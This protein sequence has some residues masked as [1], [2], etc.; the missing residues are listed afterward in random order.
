[1]S[2]PAARRG[3]T[4]S[5]RFETNEKRARSNLLHVTDRLSPQPFPDWVVPMAATLTEQRF[6]GPDWIFE[7]KYDG[8]RLLA[9]KN[10]TDV[11]LYSRNRLPQNMPAL[12][13]AV[14]A[15]PAR[16]LILDGEIT[17]DRESAY[18]V[19]DVLWH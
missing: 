12:A 18:H 7:R 19:F 9:F 15:L 16:Q 2:R 6:T 4:L 8:I 17:W 10:A 11:R 14:A 1:M 3:W 13:A 5:S